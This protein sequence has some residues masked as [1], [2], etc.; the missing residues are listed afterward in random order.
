MTRLTGSN[1][2]VRGHI[3]YTKI[4]SRN[5]NS[6]GNINRPHDY[7]RMH[8]RTQTPTLTKCQ[9]SPLRCCSQSKNSEADL[10]S[11]LCNMAKW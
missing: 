7:T 1:S 3:A 8:A 9:V 11:T 6:V 4:F 2:S 5:I 10:M